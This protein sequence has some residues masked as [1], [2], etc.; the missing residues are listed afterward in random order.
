MSRQLFS[1]PVIICEYIAQNKRLIDTRDSSVFMKYTSHAETIVFFLEY[2]IKR[3]PHSVSNK[4]LFVYWNRD[5][6]WIPCYDYL[7]NAVSTRYII[8]YRKT[9]KKLLFPSVSPLRWTLVRHSIDQRQ[10][11]FEYSWV[12]CCILCQF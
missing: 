4:N 9:S 8:T 3:Y 7:R 2:Y 10:S 6:S 12:L 11:V 5:F 1:Y